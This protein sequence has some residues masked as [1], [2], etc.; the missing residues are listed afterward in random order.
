MRYINLHFT[1]LLTYL[2]VNRCLNSEH[3]GSCKA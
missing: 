2:P 3:H 1:K